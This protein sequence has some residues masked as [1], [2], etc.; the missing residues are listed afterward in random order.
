MFTTATRKRVLAAGAI[1]LTASL[2][3]AGCGRAGDTPAPAPTATGDTPAEGTLAPAPGFDGTTI[4]LGVL[5]VT[6]GPLAVPS[7]TILSGMQAYY[8]TLN[9]TGGVA[10]KYPVELLVQDTAYDGPTAVQQY[11]A[12]K[13]KVVA[14]TQVFGTSITNA[15]LP[16]LNADGIFAIPSS[17]EGLLLQEPSVIL[18]GGVAEID[19]VAGLEWAASE[20]PGARVCF[21]QM[22]GALG[23]SF[24]KALA[25]TAEQLGI[26]LGATVI[27]DPAITDYTPQIQQL[28]ADGCQVVFEK[29]SGVVLT[30][31]LQ[32]SAQ[33]GLDAVWIA[34]Y[35]DWTPNLKDSPLND[36]LLGH[37]Y[38]T[39]NEVS[40]GDMVAEGMADLIT[41]HD[42]YSADV[43][44]VWLY[45]NGYV[46][47]KVMHD[48][49]ER[50]VENGDLSRE[51]FATAVNSFEELDFLGIQAPQKF[52]PAGERAPATEVNIL[53]FNPEAV[54]GL[55][56]EVPS[57]ESALAK[58]FPIGG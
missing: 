3:L 54:T 8:D 2:A 23:V 17:G 33:L 1:A 5:G 49:L 4:T 36:F 39:S 40:Y 56:V 42:K 37:F 15:I 22:D 57:F 34:P 29:G 20:F 50:A 26:E 13:D 19:G 16:E 44:P 51:G 12:S 18:T 28:I 7:S 43:V 14:Y 9:E 38:A 11:A 10:G 32:N 55:S 52:G 53:S 47:A 41:A 6:S 48:F 30:T 25:W 31:A 45:V 21:A 35:S 58:E 27:L 24:G 46:S